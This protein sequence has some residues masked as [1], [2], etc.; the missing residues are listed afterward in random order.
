MPET[1]AETTRRTTAFQLIRTTATAEAVHH[2]RG[3]DGMPPANW[4]MY[5]ALTAALE[6][7]HATGTLAED[8]LLL[9]EWLATEM[10]AYVLQHQGDQERLDRWL[11]DEGDRVCQGQK[12]PHPAG[13]TA[14]EIMSV[15]AADATARPDQPA[16]ADQLARIAVPYLRYLREG[17]EVED[18]REVA[19]TFALWA[20][21]HLSALMGHDAERIASYTAERIG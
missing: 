20:G 6:T 10:I 1:T 19:L 14:V 17:S 7:W 8:S 12:H 16:G 11:R 4:E 3:G 5:R 13:P 9:T 18:A 2:R 21:A 15:I